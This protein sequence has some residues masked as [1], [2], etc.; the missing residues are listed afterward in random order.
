MP[1]RRAVGPSDLGPKDYL[2]IL[3]G[4]KT[5]AH[6]SSTWAMALGPLVSAPRK[7]SGE[8]LMRA[9]PLLREFVGAG[10]WEGV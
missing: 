7:V 9:M 2:T 1:P 4:W 5:S 10:C 8:A 6:P 3:Q